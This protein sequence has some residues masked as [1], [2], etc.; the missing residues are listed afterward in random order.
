MRHR[1][2][3]QSKRRAD[4][5]RLCTLSCRLLLHPDRVCDGRVPQW[6]QK[7][8]PNIGCSRLLR[9]S[10]RAAPA[11]NACTAA[12]ASTCARST[13]Q[14]M[15]SAVVD[16]HPA[17]PICIAAAIAHCQKTLARLALVQCAKIARS[18]G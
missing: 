7:A 3:R 11:C 14:S 16:K 18:P 5:A 6:P 17:A 13:C 10:G 4:A 2:R 1:L 15:Q 9:T 12:N 8:E